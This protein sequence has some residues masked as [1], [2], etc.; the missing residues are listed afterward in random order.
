MHPYNVGVLEPSV[1]LEFCFQLIA[2]DTVVVHLPFRVV[3]DFDG[4]FSPRLDMHAKVDI[5]VST[6]PQL[7]VQRVSSVEFPFT[8][9]VVAGG[10]VLVRTDKALWCFAK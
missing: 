3:D 8:S 6:I 9:V 5:G 10:E 7:F 1:N 2:C 4:H